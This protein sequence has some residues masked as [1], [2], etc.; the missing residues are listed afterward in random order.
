VYKQAM[1]LLGN[2]LA[3]SHPRKLGLERNMARLLRM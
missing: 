1:Q 3:D 2:R